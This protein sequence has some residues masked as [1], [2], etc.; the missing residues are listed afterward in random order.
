MS[1]IVYAAFGC[2][3][4]LVRSLIGIFKAKGR[5]EKIKLGKVVR[6]AKLSMLSGTVL[7]LLIGFS[8][9]ISFTSG[10]IGGDIIEGIYRAMKN[11]SFGNK[12]IRQLKK[13]LKA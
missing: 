11:T 7:G 10:Y 8:P 6:T 13:I 5:G 4:G 3:G 1:S 12:I 2:F 9:V